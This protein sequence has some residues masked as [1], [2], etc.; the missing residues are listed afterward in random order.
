VLIQDRAPLQLVCGQHQRVNVSWQALSI[1]GNGFT[2][3][4]TKN[5]GDNP[6]T[7]QPAVNTASPIQETGYCLNLIINTNA[8]CNMLFAGNSRALVDAPS[9]NVNVG[10]HQIRTT[11]RITTLNSHTDPTA[12]MANDANFYGS[13]IG[14]NVSIV[15]DYQ[16]GRAYLHYD[17]K[18]K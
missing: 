18:L 1:S 2:G 6:S 10:Y 3:G 14:G 8:S 9:A 13:I 4:G 17:T 15:S 7:Q 16:S 5:F 11:P 12:V